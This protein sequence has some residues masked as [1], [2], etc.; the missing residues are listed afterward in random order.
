MPASVGSTR[1][2]EDARPGFLVIQ[3]RQEVDLRCH[4]I[5]LYGARCMYFPRALFLATI[6]LLAEATLGCV[7]AS[8]SNS[9]RTEKVDSLLAGSGLKPADIP[10]AAVLVRKS[11]VTDLER[12]YGVT[13]LRTRRKITARTNF[14]FASLTK[15][16]TAMAIM[17]LAHDGKLH[18]EDRLT[19]FFP[20]F[21]E[22]G[23]A[24]TIRNLL[25]H[26]SG[27]QDYEDLMGHPAAGAGQ[28]QISD[29]EVLQL[30]ERQV[31][32]EVRT[33]LK[34]GLQQLRVCSAGADC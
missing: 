5:T 20:E 12:S 14:R 32:N 26:T 33:G 3:T 23:R 4:Q 9:M 1:V 27:L 34:L 19:D 8:N 10:G 16:F 7:H 2:K 31:K 13:D 17:Q 25:N 21:P 6:V 18:Y 24:I 29:T 15:Q 30:L 22:Y 28:K 11:G